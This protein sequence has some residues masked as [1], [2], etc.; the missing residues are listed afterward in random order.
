MKSILSETNKL[1][2]PS[3]LSKY[4]KF[5]IDFRNTEKNWVK[6]FRFWDN[7]ISTSC[8][9][10]SLLMKENTW[11]YLD[12]QFQDFRNYEDRIFRVDFLAEWSKNIT[13]KVP[14]RFKQSFGPFNMLPVHK[15]SDTRLLR[16][17]S[18]P[19]FCSL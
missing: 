11:Q 5:Y 9:R 6:I 17:L 3:F 4:C 16:D 2:G 10:H 14:C 12:K 7:C 15:C 18:F 19:A 8:I 1:W 13:K